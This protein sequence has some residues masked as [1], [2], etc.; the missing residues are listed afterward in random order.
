MGRELRRVP[1]DF[2][3]PLD[4]TWD[5][6]LNTVKARP[7]PNPCCVNGSTAESHALDC[8]A[9]YIAIAASN[10]VER[11][12][13]FVP[14]K[15]GQQIIMKNGYQRNHPHPYL[16]EMGI[17]D[18]GPGL[19]DILEKLVGEPFKPSLGGYDSY[20]VYRALVKKLELPE[21]W[22]TCTGCNGESMHPD[23]VK[24][25]ND[26]EP[27]QP[28]RGEGYQVWQTV[29][30]GGPISPVFATPEELATWMSTPGNGWKTD[31]GSTYAQWMK[32]IQGPGWVPS[33][34]L[35]STG[36]HSGVQALNTED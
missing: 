3:W 12:A 22:A 26:W 25:Y 28:P 20:A 14:L 18:V 10:S 29:S 9:R 32:F 6:F 13:D 31:S 34:I 4:T 24:A 27:T 2:N 15:R 23:D 17:Q 1:L 8:F 35:D 11:P 7:C 19:K 33:M 30:E 16:T 5:G 21:G 36:V